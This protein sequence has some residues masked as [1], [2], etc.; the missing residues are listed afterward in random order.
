MDGGE[1]RA[2]KA[3][4]RC[5]IQRGRSSSKVREVLSR[6]TLGGDGDSYIEERMRGAFMLESLL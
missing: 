3:I 2:R 4:A 6:Q 5:G 1:A